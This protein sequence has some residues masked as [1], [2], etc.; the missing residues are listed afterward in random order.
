VTSYAIYE[1]SSSD[2]YAVPKPVT[3]KAVALASSNAIANANAIPSPG[4]QDTE[5]KYP[6]L[7]RRDSPKPQRSP[8]LRITD[9]F[10][11]DK[12]SSLKTASQQQKAPVPTTKP[13]GRGAVKAALESALGI[14]AKSPGRDAAGKSPQAQ[15]RQPAKIQAKDAQ[16]GC[17][18]NPRRGRWGWDGANDWLKMCEWIGRKV[19][20]G[21]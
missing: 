18:V 5:P 13:L 14:V 7:S 15:Q 3:R 6:A 20:R 1:S 21:R 16:G 10:G 8:T 4:L 9:F 2:W 17:I 11:R 19:A 12:E